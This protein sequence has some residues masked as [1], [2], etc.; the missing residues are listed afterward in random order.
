M[1][2]IQSSILNIQAQNRTTLFIKTGYLNSPNRYYLY[3]SNI[4]LNKESIAM[5]K[6]FI[7]ASALLLSAVALAYNTSGID[8]KVLRSFQAGFPHAENVNWEVLPGNYVVNFTDD[9]VRAKITYQKNG[10]LV[11]STR[12]Y[13]EQD[14]P[15]YL[16]ALVK[17]SFPG[18]AI[19]G[20][21]EIAS[22]SDTELHFK[23]VYYI[24]LVDARVW[25]TI[26][27]DGDGEITVAEK[28]T[29]A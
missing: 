14:L 9:R 20:V 16:R 11:S 2:N 25:I 3:I 24:K 17:K 29:K 4:L 21:T 6:F 8:E 1:F 15:T 5:K 10:T 13:A 19:F 26:H 18:K 23:T 7:L 12:Y 22:V 28:Y 27:V